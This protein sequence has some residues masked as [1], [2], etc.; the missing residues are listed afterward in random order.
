MKRNIAMLL[1]LVLFCT[2]LLPIT[3]SAAESESVQCAYTVKVYYDMK[4]DEEQTLTVYFDKGDYIE[5][6]DVLHYFLNCYCDYC[7]RRTDAH[8]P[9]RVYCPECYRNGCNQYTFLKT[10]GTDVLAEEKG[11][12]IHVYF[13]SSVLKV[14]AYRFYG[15]KTDNEN[16]VNNAK[17]TYKHIAA[18][19]VL[20]AVILLSL[21]IL[22]I[23]HCIGS[24]LDRRELRLQRAE[25]DQRVRDAQQEKFL[26]DA[27]TVAENNDWV[28][29]ISD[30]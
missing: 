3:A 6:E 12:A 22:A 21:T 11:G 17:A 8:D 13:I 25:M 4:C 20:F 19:G 14:H 28:T 23:T 9:E 10:L 1:A 29:P 5:T 2:A 30:E 15:N 7:K 27:A 24:V 26:E 16:A 18:E